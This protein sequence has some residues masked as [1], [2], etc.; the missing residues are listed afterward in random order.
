MAK[1]PLQPFMLGRYLCFERIGGGGMAEVFRARVQGAAGFER[2]VAVKRIL[3]HLASNDE[4]VRLFI[5]EAKI[6]A[7]LNHANIVRIYELAADEGQYFMAMEYI[8]GLDLE[9]LE[10]GLLARTELLPIEL[11]ML[12][13]MEVCKGLE[14]A[15]G[16]RDADGRPLEIIHRDLSP[17]NVMISHSGE[18][19]I[20]DFGIAKA[21][22]STEQTRAGAL[23]GKFAYMSP[24]Q[25]RAEGALDRRS[26]L[27]ALGVLLYELLTGKPLFRRDNMIE[28]MNASEQALVPP[29]ERPGETIPG[30]LERIV[31]RLLA[32]DRRDRF[33]TAA[34]VV[35]A[36]GRVLVESGRHPTTLDLGAYIRL[37]QFLGSGTLPA[38]TAR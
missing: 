30:M 11:A 1:K 10:E 20:L 16:Q 2:E 21:A 13:I 7:T 9:S 34:G 24:E 3:P 23:R 5:K 26:D 38:P 14:Y 31:R 17:S 32:R 4:F 12:V 22:A 18:V 6:C 19:R 27:F 8:S 35:D 25:I 29:L 33:P 15:H 28:A 37:H 36:L